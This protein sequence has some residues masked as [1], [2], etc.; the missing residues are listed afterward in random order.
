MHSC[1]HLPPCGAVTPAHEE[2]GVELG[3]LA[4]TPAPVSCGRKE[5]GLSSRRLRVV[6]QAAADGGVIAKEEMAAD[7]LPYSGSDRLKN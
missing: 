7:G 3:E 1:S 6:T 5:P 2:L 4:K